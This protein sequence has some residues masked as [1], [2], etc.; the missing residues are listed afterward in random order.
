M[1]LPGEICMKEMPPRFDFSKLGTDHLVCWWTGCG[2]VGM[3]VLSVD[4]LIWCI[5]IVQ[6]CVIVNLKFYYLNNNKS[7]VFAIFFVQYQSDV[8]VTR[9]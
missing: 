5:L 1:L 7:S 4:H 3:F 6:K 2:Y 9:Q 8:N